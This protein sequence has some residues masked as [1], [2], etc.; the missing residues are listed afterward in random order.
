MNLK[1]TLQILLRHPIRKL[2]LGPLVGLVVWISFAF[3]PLFMVPPGLTNPEAIGPYLNGTF[4]SAAPTDAFELVP[5]YPNV[6]FNSPL[7]WTMHP[8]E[9]RVFIGQRDGK[10][11]HMENQSSVTSKTL[12]LDLS[13]EVGVV[14]DGGFL[15]MV[16]HPDF[17]KPGSP[18]RNYFYVY[19]NTKDGDGGNEPLSPLP[20]RCY[21][22][23]IW[24]GGYNILERFEVVEGTFTVRT[25]TAY[26]Q[27]MI[28][29]RH[30]NSTHYGGALVFGLDGFLYLSTGEQAQ[31]ETAQTLADNLDG[32]VLRIDVNRDPSKSHAPI[33]KL[34]QDPRGGDE[35]SGVGYWIP[36]D[37]PFPS[38]GGQTLEEY[39]S[40]GHRNPHRMTMDPVTGKL[41]IGEIGSSIH[42]EINVVKK[43][44][45]F[46]YPIFEG[47][48]TKGNCGATMYNNLPHEL[49][50]VAFPRSEANSITGGYVY[51]GSKVPG[52]YGKYICGDYG[53]GDEIW[54]VDIE[55]GVYET[56]FSS[57]PANPI[58]FGQDHEGEVYVMGLGNNVIIH[59][60]AP[61]GGQVPPPAT[62]SQ[63]GAFSNLG[64]L[65]PAQG[66]IPYDMID[67]FWSDGA[68]KKRWM[69]IPNNG[70]HNTANEQIQYSEEGE[71]VFPEGA[72]LVKHFDLPINEANPA[73]TRRLETRFTIMGQGGAVYGLTYKWRADGSD[74]D[75]LATSL[76]ES[77]TIATPSGPRTQTWHYPSRTECLTCHNQAVGGTLGPR[78]RY[79]NKNFTYPTTG[80]TANQLV[81]LSALGI[82]NQTITDAQVNN[83][84][85]I[86]APDDGTASLEHRARSYL[87]LNCSYCHRPGTGNRGVFDARLSTPLENQGYIY[88]A[89]NNQLGNTNAYVI[90]PKNITNSILHYRMNSR[91]PQVMMPPL[92]TNMVDLEGVQLVEA[93]INSL[94]GSGPTGNGTGL[95]ATYYNNMNFTNQVL[96]RVDPEINFNWG[97]G[98]PESRI[99]PNTFSVRWEGLVEAPTS[100]TY[101][102]Y[103]MSDDGIRLWINNQQII[104]NWTDH[105]PTEDLGTITLTAGQQVPVRMEFYENGGGALAELR[106]STS[107]IPKQIIPRGYLYPANGNPTTP[108]DCNGSGSITMERWE[109]IGNSL[110]TSAIPLNTQPSAVTSLDN[111]E[112]PVNAYDNY[113][114]RV[115]GYFCAPQSG[116]YTFWIASDDNGDLYIS[117]DENPANKTRVAWVPGW[118]SSRLWDKYPEQKSS[119]IALEAGKTYYIEALMKEAGGGDNL[120]VG[121]TLP[122][123]TL[124]RPIPGKYLSP[125]EGGTNPPPPGNSQDIAHWPLDSD[126]NDKIGNADGVLQGGASL[127][128]DP[129][130]GQ[131]LSIDSNGERVLVSPKPQLQVGASG[132][133]FSIAFWMNLSQGST[134]VWRSIMNKGTTNNERTFAMWMRPGDNRLHYRISTTSSWNEGGDSRSAIPLNTWTHIAYV[135]EG[136]S[137][138]LYINGVVDQQTSL[139]GVSISNNGNLY[140]GDSPWYTPALCKMDDI[141]LY[142][143]AIDPAGVA[144]SSPATCSSSGT[145]TMD[146][147]DNIGTSMSTTAIPLN[148]APSAISNI[149]IFEIPVNAG[150]T[151]GVRLRGYICAPE[152]GNYTFW[153]ASDDNGELFLSSDANPSNKSRIAWVPG[154]TTSRLWDKYPEQKSNSIALEAGKTYY[155]EAL[156]KERLGGDNLSVGW[157]LPD[158]T[159]ERPIPGSYLSS[160]GSNTVVS[161]SSQHFSRSSQRNEDLGYDTRIFPNPSSDRIQVYV[162]NMSI[163]KPITFSLYNLQGQQLAQKVDMRSTSMDVSNLPNGLYLLKA[164]T[165]TWT[166]VIQFVKN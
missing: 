127:V 147:W 40:I 144:A 14:W 158:G 26:R 79:L 31:H 136:Q 122:D 17:G 162:E 10:V 11:Y 90:E 120:A 106:W 149:D 72:V 101:T 139:N 129:Q 59:T 132:S 121:W 55:T 18:N 130:R 161:S 64:N 37:N 30:Y 138:K 48:A 3:V 141:R 155:I 105:G 49:P 28:K 153:I 57:K 124:E 9:N 131:V 7:T 39:W 104:N 5:A 54:S 95:L 99:D 70:S 41:Y 2:L 164:H 61:Q 96:Q 135:K 116:N 34:P 128:N 36:N 100:G 137:L 143:Y 46:G 16:L 91:D 77:Y 84:L 145:I 68:T 27:V 140:F 165:S 75:L 80:I 108:T 134:G 23:A 97:T 56:L 111:F 25:G 78:T 156:M 76:D 151:Y 163:G 160:F 33:R 81:T 24:N 114:V 103:T 35:V 74:A 85:T 1:S 60:F 6:T 58:S 142:G 50:L 8:R 13:A 112:I 146:R 113:G 44:A 82:L 51:R 93:W 148:T 29:T 71:W 126:V 118:T 125:F 53:A 133:D 89:L 32:G 87:D 94:S 45:N 47:P 152:S 110:L 102:F 109:N 42:E 69:A 150:E 63:T 86:A 52:L 38:P 119:A 117:T 15:G 157:T 123:G 88:G 115:R 154:W 22:D 20:Q 67:D 12:F 83:F 21:A 66:L 107:G 159:L 73:Q 43:G 92:A 4:P 62:L 166:Q 19:Y 65:E 98:S